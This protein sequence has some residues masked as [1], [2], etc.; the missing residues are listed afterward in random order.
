[1]DSLEEAFRTTDRAIGK[2]WGREED[3]SLRK[4]SWTKE[5]PSEK[6]LSFLRRKKVPPEMLVDLSKGKA[7][8]MI[9]RLI[10]KEKGEMDGK[11]G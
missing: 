7:T 3:W 11:S 1:M 6:Q 2:C 8:A 10:L 4:S 9:S 5:P